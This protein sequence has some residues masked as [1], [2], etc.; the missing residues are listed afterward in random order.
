M[1][2]DLEPLKQ[3]LDDPSGCGPDLEWDDTYTQ[4][5]ADLEA[6]F[7]SRADDYHW[8][9]NQNTDVEPYARRCLGVL[10]RTRDVRLLVALVKLAALAGDLVQ[11]EAGLGLLRHYLESA[12][13][14]VHP[15]PMD[16]DYT[17]RVVN[18]ER[19]DEFASTVL[20]LQ[21]ARV[22]VDRV[23]QLSYRDLAVSAGEL[24]A[25]E[26]DSHP[27]HN[28]IERILRTCELD[29]L[30]HSRDLLA[31]MVAH[32]AAI[33]SSSATSTDGL[34]V[35]DFPKLTPLLGKIFAALEAA[36]VKRD[37]T[38]ALA[39][40]DVPDGAEGADDATPEGEAAAEAA[41]QTVVVAAP[42]GAVRTIADAE[43]ALEAVCVYF[44]GNEP[45][46]PAILLVRQAQA[47][48]GLSFPQI[49]QRLAPTSLPEA[50]IEL[51]GPNGFTLS[52]EA[53]GTEFAAGPR[54]DHGDSPASFDADTRAAAAGL[55]SEVALWYR[56][57]E[58]SNPIP[59]LLDRAR[60]LMA[61]DFASLLTELTPKK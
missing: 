30:V 9:R 5:S 1:Q 23:G 8:F 27:S 58:P 39:R 46:S 26:G 53:L 40:T 28:D 47:L 24:T 17:L 57:C 3:P 33:K 19:L 45:S 44:D 50:R 10:Q 25:R 37:P 35:V 36:V 14:H 16:G 60:Q 34:V 2:I 6:V 12:W 41:L 48:V 13:E 31:A 4:L 49:L 21:Y 51:S 18:L 20:P 15:Q 54:A 42:T 61:K 38:L 7:P 32:V 55:M 43:A 56:A 52:L 22:L 29:K 59:M 11:T